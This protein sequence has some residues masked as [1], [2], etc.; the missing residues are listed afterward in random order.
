MDEDAARRLLERL[1]EEQ[2]AQLLQY[3]LQLLREDDS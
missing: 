3:V 2:K 1:S